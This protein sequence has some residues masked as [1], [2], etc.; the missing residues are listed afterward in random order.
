MNFFASAPPSKCRNCGFRDSDCSELRWVRKNDGDVVVVVD[1]WMEEIEDI[2]PE[3][4]GIV[5]GILSPYP[6]DKKIAE[7]YRR[8]GFDLE[9]IT[10]KCYVTLGTAVYAV[11]GDA[12]VGTWEDYSELN[13]NQTWFYTPYH[14]N[15]GNGYMIPVVPCPPANSLKKKSFEAFFLKRQ[16]E[17]AKSL[18][19][20]PFPEPK[21]HVVDDVAVTKDVVA[22]DLE[23]S[24]VN[25]HSQNFRVGWISYC[26]DK[27]NGYVTAFGKGKMEAIN[28]S[29]A[30]AH[31]G[32][33]DLKALAAVSEAGRVDHDTYVIAK[34]MNTSRRLYGLKSLAWLIGFGGYDSALDDYKKKYNVPTYLDIPDKIL[35]QYAGLDAIVTY[36]LFHYYHKR[37]ARQPQVWDLYTNYFRHLPRVYA[38]IESFGF[39]VDKDVLSDLT[40]KAR[41]DLQKYRKAWFANFPGKDPNKAVDV[42]AAITEAGIP[43]DKTTPTGAMDTTEATLKQA[44]FKG[45]TQLEDL[46]NIRKTEK[47]LTT[48]LG[49]VDD[50]SNSF[51]KYIQPDGKVYG[52]YILFGT[53]TGRIAGSHDKHTPNFLALPK[54]G[55][56]A[57]DL[58]YIFKLPQGWIYTSVDYSGFQLRLAA[59]QAGE[60]RMI[61]IINSGGDLHCNTAIDLFGLDISLEEFQS[62]KNEPDLA[63]KRQAG[64]QANFAMLFGGSWRTIYPDVFTTWS[65]SAI[66]SYIDNPTGKREV[67]V[68]SVCEKIKDR[69]ERAYPGLRRWAKENAQIIRKQGYIDSWHGLRRHLPY[70]M[71]VGPESDHRRIADEANISVNSPTQSMEVV[72]ATKALLKIMDDLKDRDSRVVLTVYDSIIFAGPESESEFV[73]ETAKK[74][75]EIPE[76]VFGCKIEVDFT[77]SPALG[78]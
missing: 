4:W 63:W 73:T 17:T 36:R 43:I 66:T 3:D 5:R 31:N 11:S 55:A 18:R 13:F 7:T 32:K 20:I 65:D 21:I 78:L 9:E 46:I 49:G 77:Y 39:D 25:T 50:S 70:S 10:A 72:E 29:I 68:R 71:Y 14:F 52:A 33:Y 22:W 12:Q 2:F 74:H 41:A 34:M 6:P 47:L 60:R 40:E 27:N 44:I 35:T 42:K 64:K 38:E 56:M 16:I 15:I 28:R 75:M 1:S 69:F 67:D 37:A 48:W 58:R 23:T 24:S 30:I 26:E 8:C 59:I 62:R 45:Y 61:E 76:S 54:H 57:K 53:K 51:L 19:P